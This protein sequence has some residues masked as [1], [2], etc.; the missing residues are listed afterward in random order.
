MQ[1]VFHFADYDER[2]LA[3][4]AMIM[5]NKKGFKLDFGAHDEAG[6]RKRVVAWR[7]EVANAL[8]N[9]PFQI[10]N[11]EHMNVI[12]AEAPTT[13]ARLGDV[14]D[15]FPAA[16]MRKYGASIV[17]AVSAFLDGRPAPPLNL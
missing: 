9:L 11:E 15:A 16:K 17:A 14:L 4:I 3:Q 12:A 13:T 7:R 10:I 1:R 6:L 2:Q 5:I 8:N